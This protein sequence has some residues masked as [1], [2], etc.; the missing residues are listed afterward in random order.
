MKDISTFFSSAVI[1]RESYQTPITETDLENYVAEAIWK[2]FD[3]SRLEIATKSDMS[4][5]D[6]VLKDARVMGFKID[7][8][9]VLN[10]EGFTGKTLEVST[11][12]TITK[13]S[14]GAFNL[15]NVEEGA[16][17][18]HLLRQNQGV[19]SL[20]FAET[21]AT[22]T[23]IFAASVLRTSRLG[24]VKWGKDYVLKAI[25]EFFSLDM[26]KDKAT[27]ERIYKRFINKELSTAVL[28]KLENIFTASFKEFVSG[29]AELLR[30]AKEFKS[31]PASVFM[32]PAPAFTLP[33]SIFQKKFLF[34][35][36]RAK[37]STV[38]PTSDGESL[39]ALLEDR[40]KAY[41]HYNDIAKTRIKWVNQSN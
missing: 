4:E 7:G 6:L 23:T 37:I 15:K 1:K 21:L 28:S 17:R 33:E 32:N 2:V 19:G 9:K 22:S 26:E 13:K 18:A 24:E 10:P 25:A 41:K 27:A 36:K 11:M 20:L 14:F 38:E 29:V 39:Y 16:L 8:H 12:V 31:S 5:F 3:K 40:D 34:N 35:D 30:E